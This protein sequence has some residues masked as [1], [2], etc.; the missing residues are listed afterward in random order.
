MPSCLLAGDSSTKAQPKPSQ[1]TTTGARNIDTENWYG[2][3]APSGPIGIVVDTSKEGPL[4]HSLKSTSPMMGLI[5]PGDLI[6]ALDG[7]D[8]RKM[9]AAA[10]TRLMAK[11]SRQKERKITLYSKDG[12]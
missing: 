2:A 7:E 4:V 12:F 10:L 6:V 5:S 9:L 3:Y 1:Y 8:T 11:K